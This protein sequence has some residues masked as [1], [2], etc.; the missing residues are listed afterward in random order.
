MAL[1]IAI[2]GLKSYTIANFEKEVAMT[3]TGF[4]IFF[5][6]LILFVVIVAV[7]V[8]AASVSGAVGAIEDD[9]ESVEADGL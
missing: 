2:G 6:I 9:E 1:C 5:F 8:V 3:E 7:V 4:L